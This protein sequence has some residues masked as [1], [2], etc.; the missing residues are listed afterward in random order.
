[1]IESKIQTFM[2]QQQTNTCKRRR[3]ERNFICNENT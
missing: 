2:D 3:A 1:M